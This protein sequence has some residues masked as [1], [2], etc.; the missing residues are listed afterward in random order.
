MEEKSQILVRPLQETDLEQLH[1][2]L[3]APHLFPHYMQEPISL[4]GVDR[5]FQPRIGGDH[6]CHPL[7][8]SCA[9]V[10]FGYLQWYLNRS[11]PEYGV[12]TIGEIDGVSCDYF[13]GTR[14]I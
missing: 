8:A 3:N 2:W 4:E 14:H 12:G 5:K 11:V 10:P 1:H 9:D 6:Y 7:I 13:I